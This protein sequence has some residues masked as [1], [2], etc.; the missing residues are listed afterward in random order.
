M[1][2]KANGRRTSG[3]LSAM[4]RRRENPP[5]NHLHP[6]ILIIYLIFFCFH[7]ILAGEF[8][9]TGLKTLGRKQI[10]DRRCLLT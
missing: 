7:S 3:V 9:I 6:P 2:W 4:L 8:E 1:L 5:T 10:R